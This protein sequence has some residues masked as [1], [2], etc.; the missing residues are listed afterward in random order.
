MNKRKE[1]NS[2]KAL[3]RD[4]VQERKHHTNMLENQYYIIFFSHIRMQK[5]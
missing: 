3:L 5:H 2:N 4:V 1:I